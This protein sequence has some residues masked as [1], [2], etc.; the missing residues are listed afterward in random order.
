M[1]WAREREQSAQQ[2]TLCHLRQVEGR[3]YRRL[4]SNMRQSRVSAVRRGALRVLLRPERG[5]RRWEVS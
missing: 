2:C 4:L 5:E 1:R 3:R